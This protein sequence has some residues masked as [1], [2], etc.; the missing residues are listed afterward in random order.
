MM[1]R[2]IWEQGPLEQQ[3]MLIVMI[4]PRRKNDGGLRNLIH[5]IKIIKRMKLTVD[6]SIT[7]DNP[8]MWK[9]FTKQVGNRTE[10]WIID[11]TNRIAYLK[12]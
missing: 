8:E 1:A 4:L 9:E 11:E 7:Y 2:F 3:W 10:D 12:G 6:V 5:R